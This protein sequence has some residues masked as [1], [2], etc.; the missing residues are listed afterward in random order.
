M[1]S[2][3][4]GIVVFGQSLEGGFVCVKICIKKGKS[5]RIERTG[6]Y[7]LGTFQVSVNNFV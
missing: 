3:A 1:T 6:K 2:G 5:A 7:L 4:G